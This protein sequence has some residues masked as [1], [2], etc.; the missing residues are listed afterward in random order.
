MILKHLDLLASLCTL[1]ASLKIDAKSIRPG[2]LIKMYSLKLNERKY[3]A[4]KDKTASVINL[5]TSN[6][7]YYIAYFNEKDEKQ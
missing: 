1:S 5:K 2:G 4:F 3:I 7:M 6:Y